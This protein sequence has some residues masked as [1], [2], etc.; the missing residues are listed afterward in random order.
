M[1]TITIDPIPKKYVKQ[2]PY[3]DDTGI[4]VPIE[5]YAPEGIE[6]CY[7]LVMSK[8]MFIEAYNKF[9]LW[10]KNNYDSMF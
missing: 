7:K 2:H 5:E 3:V 1:N 4:W 6:S 9:I 8:E 10:E